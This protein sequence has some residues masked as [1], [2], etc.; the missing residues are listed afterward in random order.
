MSNE[1]TAYLE[2][3]GACQRL[4]AWP[5]PSQLQPGD[6]IALCIPLSAA[7]AEAYV[8]YLESLSATDLEISIAPFTCEAAGTFRLW[9]LAAARIRLPAKQRVEARHDLI[10]IRLAQVG[11]GFGAD[12]L[13]GPVQEDRHLPLAGMTR[14]N[15]TT[16]AGL[17][18][19]MELAGLEAEWAPEQDSQ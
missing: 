7:G 19:L 8:D 6:A 13:A 15:E 17:S 12:T 1:A 10:G 14:P 16:R 3:E 2:R 5:E 4:D 9:A 11:V 18:A